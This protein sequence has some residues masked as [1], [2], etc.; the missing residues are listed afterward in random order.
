MSRI[1]GDTHQGQSAGSPPPGEPVFLLVG[2]LRKPHGLQGELVMEVWTEFPERLERGR[3]VFVGPENKPFLVRSVRQKTN[4]LLVAFQDI[5]DS[6]QAGSLRNQWVFV[7]ADQVPPLSDGEY[8]HHQIV[9][10]QVISESE[11]N[12]G[13]VTDILE[14]GSNDVLIVHSELGQDILLPFTDEVILH[15]DLEGGIINVHLLPGLLP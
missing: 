10:L 11:K 14:T 9:G 6:E 8:Y 4:S 5:H 7:R 1:S 2:K 13:V 3:T 12:L 15:V